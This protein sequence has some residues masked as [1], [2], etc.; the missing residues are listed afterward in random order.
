MLIGWRVG[1]R[2]GADRGLVVAG[3][4]GVVIAREREREGAG[5]RPARQRV[6]ARGVRR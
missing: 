1:R 5:C 6:G 4:G 3:L 2:T